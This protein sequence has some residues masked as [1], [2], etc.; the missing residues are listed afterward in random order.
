VHRGD[1]QQA[2]AGIDELLLGMVVP[3]DALTVAQVLE[4]RPVQGQPQR[5]AVHRHY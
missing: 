2:A 1:D 3:V 5:L 4:R